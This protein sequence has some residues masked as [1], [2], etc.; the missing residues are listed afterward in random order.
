MGKKYAEAKEKVEQI[1]NIENLSRVSDELHFIR[2][3]SYSISEF[4]DIVRDMNN[5]NENDLVAS[6]TD[7]L[8][9]VRKNSFL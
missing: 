6:I 3:I 8:L 5:P 7:R 1:K 2:E 9:E 4:L